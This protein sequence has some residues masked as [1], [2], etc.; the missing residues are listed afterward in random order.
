MHHLA[1]DIFRINNKIIQKY[2]VKVF[3]KKN[4]AWLLRIWN[5][6]TYIIKMS[7]TYQPKGGDCSFA[8]MHYHFLF[9][10]CD[11]LAQQQIYQNTNGPQTHPK[12][13][14]WKNINYEQN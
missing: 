14:H 7:I 13:K 12:F 8:F 9:S 5:I 1:E 11:I 4:K 2:Y 6:H 3:E 10:H